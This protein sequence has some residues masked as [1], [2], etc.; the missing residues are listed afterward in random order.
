M[1][2]DR[3]DCIRQNDSNPTSI[4]PTAACLTREAPESPPAPRSSRGFD[5][6]CAVSVHASPRHSSANDDAQVADE[7]DELQVRAARDPQL[8]R[9]AELESDQSAVL[10]CIE[11]LPDDEAAFARLG[12]RSIASSSHQACG[13]TAAK[14]RSAKHRASEAASDAIKQRKKLVDYADSDDEDSP[15]DGATSDFLA[16]LDARDSP[17]GSEQQR[18]SFVPPFAHLERQPKRLL[19][20]VLPVLEGLDVVAKMMSPAVYHRSMMRALAALQHHPERIWKAL[21]QCLRGHAR[22]RGRQTELRLVS[23]PQT[24]V[25][26]K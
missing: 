20:C 13:M 17:I 8:S 3:R 9:R 12:Q 2:C 6:S 18:P 23:P 19:T 1:Y 21:V 4:E 10:A 15:D 25:L 5:F 11:T 7:P 16:T 22:S 24:T 26:P 14:T